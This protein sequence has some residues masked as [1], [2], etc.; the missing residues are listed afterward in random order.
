MRKILLLL[1]FALL[2][3]C[4]PKETVDLLPPVEVVLPETEREPPQETAPPTVE[5]KSPQE[6]APPTV[7]T[8]PPQETEDI[9]KEEPERSTETEPPAVATCTISISCKTLTEHPDALDSDKHELVPETGWILPPTS[10]EIEEGESVFD[11]LRRVCQTHGI[12][13][14][15]TISPIY[16]SAY[17]EG[18]AN[19]YEFDAGPQSGWVYSVNGV[20]PNY[21][22]S[23]FYPEAGD[24]VCWEYKIG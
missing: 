17:I 2:C 21:G 4:A 16:Q 10:A 18:I 23:A 12:L 8:E 6:I 15:F 14:E 20:T 5:G 13:M 1:G 19:L 7:E 11:L 3:G 9:P 22:C 24:T